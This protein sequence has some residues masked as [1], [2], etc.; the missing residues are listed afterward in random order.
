MKPAENLIELVAEPD[1][2]CLA[3]WKAR[4]GKES[5]PE[6]VAYRSRLGEN[7]RQLRLRLLYGTVEVGRYH[8][9]RIF[10]PKERIICAADFG[11]RVLHH[12]L[13]NVCHSHFERFQI[14]DSYA[15]RPGK[16]QYAALDR[17]KGYTRRYGWFCKMDVRK[18]FDSIGHERLC[19]LLE[20]RFGD[21]RLMEIFRAIICSY[22]SAPGR[23][24]PI[25]HLTSQ[26]FANFYLAHADHYIKDRLRVRAYV[27]YM[28]DMVFWC[29]DR[30][31]AVRIAALFR[32]FI[33]GELGL[34]LKPLCINSC[35]H[36]LPFLG[37]VL[38]PGKVRLRSG[39]KKRF[40]R[41]VKRYDMKL[42]RGEWSQ[43]QYSR[44]IGPLVAFTRYA[45]AAALRRMAFG[46]GAD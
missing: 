27:R 20:R 32:D 17:A 43:E 28:D 6:V 26:Y 12:A 2:L 24:L 4:R 10:D 25:G 31:E 46:T 44:H 3:F 7:L 11:E 1:N 9:F 36:G 13:M 37:Y 39:S 45:D 15:T 40:L 8:T 14:F 18:F 22:E 42:C 35:T 16:G 21:A 34:A 30:A 38:F 23:G 33:A 19:I 41:K 5:R 29:D